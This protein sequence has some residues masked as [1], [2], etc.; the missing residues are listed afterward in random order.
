MSKD[1]QEQED[2]VDALVAGALGVSIG[3]M[4]IMRLDESFRIIQTEVERVRQ[5]LQTLREN[6]LIT[7]QKFHEIQERRKTRQTDE[8]T[9][10]AE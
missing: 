3:A 8:D 2:V 10:S 9:D 6:N 1:K 4:S 7:A 5:E